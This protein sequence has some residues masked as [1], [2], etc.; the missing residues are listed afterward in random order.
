MVWRSTCIKKHTQQHPWNRV[1]WGKTHQATLL[2][3]V[4]VLTLTLAS[5]EVFAHREMP[6]TDSRKGGGA[7]EELTGLPRAVGRLDA[8]TGLARRAL[9]VRGGACAVCAAAGRARAATPRPRED[10]A[11]LPNIP[12]RR[13]PRTARPRLPLRTNRRLRATCIAAGRRGARARTRGESPSSPSLGSQSESSAAVPARTGRGEPITAAA[14]R[15]P[16]CRRSGVF[17]V[18]KV[19]EWVRGGADGGMR[20]RKGRL[21]LYRGRRMRYR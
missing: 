13:R 15:S 6:Q 12:I 7:R 20:W 11:A 21:W 8:V 2:I 18:E 16:G 17:V 3:S 9:I 1:V 14:D 19:R 5:S 4:V 10:A